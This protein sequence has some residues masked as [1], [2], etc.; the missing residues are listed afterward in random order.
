MAEILQ[1]V[2]TR[3]LPLSEYIPRPISLGRLL[4]AL[5]PP[6]MSFVPLSGWLVDFRSFFRSSPDCTGLPG[7]QPTSQLPLTA[8][9]HLAAI[10][11]C[12]FRG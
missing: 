5:R 7:Q 12:C 1:E 11:L 10:T 2:H 6:R 8:A 4:L 9:I 3:L